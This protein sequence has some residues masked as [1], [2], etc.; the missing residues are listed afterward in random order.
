MLIIVAIVTFFTDVVFATN[1]DY[2]TFTLI[3]STVFISAMISF[4]QQ[5]NSNKAAQKLKRLITNKID[6]IRDE[7]PNTVDV[8]DI[9]TGDILNL[10]S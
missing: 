7:L 5:T 2:L 1:K 8:E 6:V 9:V 3:I 4:F 10:S